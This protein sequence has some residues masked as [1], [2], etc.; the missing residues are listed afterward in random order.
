M[1]QP[2]AAPAPEA[3]VDPVV[4]QVVKNALD[5]VAE[6]MAATLQYTAHSTVI[7]EVLD[8]ATA[9][10]DVRGRLISQTAAAPTFV[11]ALGPTLRFIVEQTAPLEEWEEGDVF[12][13]NDPYLGG[14][15][16]LPDLAMFRPIF[17]RG[18]LVGVAG[19]IAHHVDVGGTAP[20][21][22]YMTAREIYQEGLRIPP[23]RL[24]RRGELQG[25]IKRLLFAN[26]RIPAYVWGDM[27]AQL[28]CLRIGEQG[29]R[30][31]LDR[32]TPET[33]AA[34]VEAL[35]GYSE[36]LM[37]AGLRKIPEG[38]YRFEDKLDDDGGSDEPVR[39]AVELTVK[40]D[41]VIA[42]FT[43]SSPQRAAPIN[44]SLSMTTAV[45]HYCL[46]AAVGADVP[47]NEG[48]FRPV[49]VIAPEGTVINALPPAPVVG[50]M[51]TL[52]R[53]CDAV[54]GALAQALPD[55]IPA[56]YYGMST[57]T[58]LSGVGEDGG[59]GWVLFEIAVGGWGGQSWRD[60]FESCS[61]MIHNPANTPIEM[62]ERMH[63][64]R[65]ERYALRED[66]GGPGMFRGGMG[67]ERD[68]RLLSGEGFVT[69]L[70][71][72]MKAGPYGLHGGQD[73]ARTEL[74]LNP[75]TPGERRLPSKVTGVPIKAGD[76][77]RMRTTGGGG[78]GDP[79]KRGR[80]AVRRDLALGKISLKAARETYGL[81]EG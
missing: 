35:L 23:V 27:E 8:F 17:W 62:I 13:V 2:I 70:G 33:V 42:D 44:C 79:R 75:G 41:E 64:V 28:A 61:A 50:R 14:S 49:T 7:R 58:M 77:F 6:Q 29:F 56:A 25:D 73:G 45:V 66:S 24:F 32:W 15:Q 31:L 12:L 51:A 26:M 78:W 43:G 1:A 80:D 22:Y 16:H 52:H 40:G 65:V 71:D 46:V 48:C 60:G 74:I 59:M 54:N 19:C 10:L 37:R 9:L 81:D 18:R 4:M 20:G 5:S 76:V 53:T 11:N 67:L 47:V 63:P 72:R 38:R 69:V 39:I 3:A 30:E 68:T 55:R 36:R 57:T 21:S 34:C